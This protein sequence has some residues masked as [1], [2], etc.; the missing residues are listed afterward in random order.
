MVCKNCGNHISD[1]APVCLHCGTILKVPVP[2]IPN[3][4]TPPVPTPPIP[5][6]PTPVTPFQ[7]SNEIPSQY[8]P[9]SPWAFFWLK[10][11]FCIPVIGFIFLMIFTF[12]GSNLSRRNFARSY[13]CGLLIA[14][15]IFLVFLVIA[16]VAAG[17]IGAAMDNIF[18]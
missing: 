5:T 8:R 6:P 14:V 9:M 11:L 3:I 13:W 10:I 7:Q 4:P 16:A 18:G 12:D 1:N 15:I 17:G 2:P